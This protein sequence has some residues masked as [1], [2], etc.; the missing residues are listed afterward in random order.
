MIH[1]SIILRVIPGTVGFLLVKLTSIKI[2]FGSIALSR[3]KNIHILYEGFEVQI[4]EIALK[5]NIFNSEISNPVQIFIKNVEIGE[6]IEQS[7]AVPSKKL[8]KS[9]SKEPFKQIPSF[10]VTFLQVCF[11]L[12]IYIVSLWN[13][14]WI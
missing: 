10:L 2:K 13:I 9:S 3:A 5:S 7:Q 12:S 6:T 8:S 14:S 11:I 1:N 4:E